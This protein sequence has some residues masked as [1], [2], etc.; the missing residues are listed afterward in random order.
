MSWFSPS[1]SIVFRTTHGDTYPS[2][3][4]IDGLSDPE[5]EALLQQT[6]DAILA[7]EVELE[8]RHSAILVA[9]SNL[10]NDCENKLQKSL[11]NFKIL[12][13]LDARA[14][15]SVELAISVL[16]NEQTVR[17]SKVY[18][19]F[20]NDI[21][22]QCGRGLALLCAAS[23]GKHN[24][25]GMNAQSRT[26]LVYYLKSKKASLSSSDLDSLAT[27]YELPPEIGTTR[28]PNM[29][30]MIDRIGRYSV[31]ERRTEYKGEDRVST[32][33]GQDQTE[34]KETAQ[35]STVQNR[36]K[37]GGFHD[38]QG[39][40]NNIYFSDSVHVLESTNRSDTTLGQ[41]RFRRSSDQ[42]SL[43][44]GKDAWRRDNGLPDY[45]DSPRSKPRY[46]HHLMGWPRSRTSIE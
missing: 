32:A 24:I 1:T 21:I 15:K 11:Q 2:T 16:T 4:E 39:I 38:T 13:R 23:L 19:D 31:A 17:G 33:T 41:S 18:Q 42:S 6:R 27:Q 3:R 26:S 9:P 14:A 43:G 36:C 35:L 29:W 45:H 37:R 44:N 20:L 7:L 40:A 8:K 25:I 12:G 10:V 46:L 5:L 22:R 28:S 34:G 30:P